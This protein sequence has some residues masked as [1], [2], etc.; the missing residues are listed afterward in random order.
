MFVSSAVVDRLV[1]FFAVGTATMTTALF[2]F[3]MGVVPMMATV[4]GFVWFAV[5]AVTL[6]FDPPLE[7]RLVRRW[8][9]ALCLCSLVLFAVPWAIG[10][11]RVMVALLGL[12][13]L[14]LAGARAF[15]LKLRARADPRLESG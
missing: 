7:V 10:D 9:G 5:F 14:P 11:W 6:G 4:A 12:A 2:A 1:E 13:V 8:A 15:T 3:V